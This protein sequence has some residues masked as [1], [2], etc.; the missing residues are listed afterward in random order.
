MSVHAICM[1]MTHSFIE[2]RELFTKLF[3]ILMLL[4]WCGS[5]HTIELSGLASNWMLIYLTWNAQI[6]AVRKN[7]F[8]LFTH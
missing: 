2:Q 6:D 7:L 3:I 4:P 5:S 8:L 1:L